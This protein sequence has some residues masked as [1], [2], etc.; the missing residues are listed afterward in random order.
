VHSVSVASHCVL[1]THYAGVLPVRSARSAR[2]AVA[3]RRHK[4]N[5][6]GHGAP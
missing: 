5:N 2:A 6:E 4:L 3:E 1:V